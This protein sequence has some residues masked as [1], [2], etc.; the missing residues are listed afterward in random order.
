VTS[1]GSP[2]SIPIVS[3]DVPKLEHVA[4]L[5]FTAAQLRRCKAAA[6]SQNLRFSVWA[7]QNLVAAANAIMGQSS[8][9]LLDA[10]K[11]P[12]GNDS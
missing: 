5:K 2:F 9:A 11:L 8:G 10:P 7:R 12:G 3:N 6:R 1:Q 4:T